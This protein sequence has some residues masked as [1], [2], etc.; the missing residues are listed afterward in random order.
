MLDD[1]LDSRLRIAE[2]ADAEELAAELF[3]ESFRLPFP[4]PRANC[5]L[6]IPT[7]PENW[8]QYVARYRWPS[9]VDETVGFC[10]WIR[11]KDVYLEGG[12]CVRK[13]F[14]RRLPREHWSECAD[15]GGLAQMMM[16]AASKRLNDCNAWFGLCGDAKALA[17][18]QR[19]GYELTQ[20]GNLIVKW[21]APLGP[22]EKQSLV[23]SIAAIGAF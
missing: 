19:F 11:Y 15:K 21:F 16:Q 9:G 5:G 4:A 13:N 22:A 12:M 14:Y 23:N 17:V 2:V 20:H 18:V 1:H 8:H 3:F 10:N 7:P 6:S